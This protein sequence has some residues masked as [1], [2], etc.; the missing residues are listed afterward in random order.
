MICLQDPLIQPVVGRLCLAPLAPFCLVFSAPTI[1]EQA[2]D[3]HCAEDLWHS[4]MPVR[5]EYRAI[6]A[7][8]CCHICMYCLV[9]FFKGMWTTT[10]HTLCLSHHILDM[11]YALSCDG[12]GCEVYC[13]CLLC[14]S[15]TCKHFCKCKC[16]YISCVGRSC[17][18]YWLCAAAVHSKCVCVWCI[19]VYAQFGCG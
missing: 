2:T 11:L 3:G 5:S 7:C 16:V 1:E 18:D 6:V 15:N 19:I 14:H 10:L 12:H 8:L 9:F 17:F 13:L 4:A